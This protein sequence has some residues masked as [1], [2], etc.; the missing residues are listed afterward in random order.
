LSAISLVFFAL[1]M[2]PIVLNVRPQV[3]TLMLSKP[4]WVLVYQDRLAAIGRCCLG[5]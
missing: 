2:R 1:I 5:L 3:F 4:G